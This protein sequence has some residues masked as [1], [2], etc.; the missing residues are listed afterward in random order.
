MNSISV[1]YN[2]LNMF[3]FL[4]ELT[5]SVTCIRLKATEV[6]C[7]T[8]LKSG[9]CVAAGCLM[10]SHYCSLHWDPQTEV[11]VSEYQSASA[12]AAPCHL[13]QDD[14]WWWHLVSPHYCTHDGV[15][16][17]RGKERGMSGDG[18]NEPDQVW[19][20]VV[21]ED[22]SADGAVSC[23]AHLGQASCALPAV[24][25][26]L[27]NILQHQNAVLPSTSLHQ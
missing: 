13:R 18:V 21:G 16:W 11:E 2:V 12:R 27:V 25:Q 14:L 3:L 1:H 17:E 23:W 4:W 8:Y 5:W 10:M 19:A 20:V 6:R 7:W 22:V 24:T 15:S 26:L 9:S